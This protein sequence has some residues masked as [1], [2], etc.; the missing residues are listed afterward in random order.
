[1]S[2]DECSL[3]SLANLSLAS[4]LVLGILDASA[5]SLGAQD[6]SA[7]MAFGAPCAV[8][9]ANGERVE[10]KGHVSVRCFD[11]D[12][13][14]RL[15]L[16]L[17]GGDGRLWRLMHRPGRGVQ[18]A[19]PVAIAAGSK[20][21]WGRGYTGVVLADLTGDGLPELVV[22][23]DEDKVSVH[24]NHGSASVPRF[25]ES[26]KTIVVQGGCH[27]RF[28]LA[29]WDGDGRVDLITG[30]FGGQLS[31][32]RNTGTKTAA[33]FGPAE[34]FH[35][36]SVAYNSHPRILDF[37]RDGKLDLVLGVNWGTCTLYRNIGQPL[38]PKLGRGRTLRSAE[39][40]K[41]LNIRAHNG[42]DT[43]P[44]FADL[45]GDGVL[46]LLSGG[47][48]GRVFV[49]RGVGASGRASALEELLLSARELGP[50]HFESNESS[51]RA[52]FAA[53]GALQGDLDAGLVSGE[54]RER[55]F[56]KLAPLARALPAILGR[57]TF[58]LDVLPHAP[59]L[60]AQFWV[61]LFNVLPDSTD[62]RRRVAD[63]LGFAGGYRKLLI[64]LGVILFDNNRASER[65]LERMHALLMT[66]PKQVW[67]VQLISVAGWLGP[68]LKAHPV[69]ARTA[70][71]IFAMS[72][73]VP[74]DSF[75]ADSPR[76]GVTDVFMIC[77]AHEIAHN[78]LDT[79]GRLRRPELFERKFDALAN[80]AGTAVVYR[81]PKSRGIDFKATKAVFRKRG[82]WDG[83]EDGWRA[84]WQKYFKGKAVYDRSYA[85]GNVW[86]FL[87]SPQE[88][89]STLANQYIAD[90]E[91]MLEFS[92]TRWDAGHQNVIN[93][94]LLIADYLSDGG[95]S[96]VTYRLR[97]GG[98]MTT[99]EAR[100]ERDARGRVT[101][102]VLGG[103]VASFGY[104]DGFL[105]TEFSYR[106]R[107]ERR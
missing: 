40:G 86:F 64:D 85:R 36:I 19:A 76:K 31:W 87:D 93:Q 71:N 28:D 95:S 80:A 8:R 34:S 61:T 62:S 22:G 29:D 96:V 30:A 24:V 94:F 52:A 39:D 45:D 23:Y 102:F 2:S 48:N 56:A 63:A 66:F 49:L 50:S 5:A 9:D 107:D 78:M 101:R 35:D 82:D 7:T 46:D 57:Q 73:G 21:L 25:D 58:D 4:L 51:R 92:K 43:T 15:D 37:D 41:T 16:V 74:E 14:G 65:Q 68:G 104:G 79:V 69:K 75:P 47:K 67:D 90:S 44:E 54:E 3:G 98:E 33:R 38:A 105:V 12:G 11:W 83:D 53:L 13:N 32:H 70:V 81:S 59:M 106:D 1:M 72:L 6:V 100:L 18:F 20:T 97:R 99:G 26:A 60:A 17:G 91:L 42:D 84:A 55:L 27:G 88:G 103:K 77:L 10:I 89:F